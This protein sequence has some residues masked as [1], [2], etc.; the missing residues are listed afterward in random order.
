MSEITNSFQG[1]FPVNCQQKSISF[2][3]LSMCSLLIDG[4]DPTPNNVSQAALYVSQVIMFSYEKQSKIVRTNE[5]S[6]VNRRHLKKRET[7]LSL[8]LG[9]KLMTMRA[10]TIIQKRFLLG[11]CISYDRC[12]DI[13]NNIVVSMLEKIA[14]DAVFTGNSRK[15]LFIIIAKD[16]TDVNS[17]STKVG[18]H[19]HGTSLTIMPFL[20]N[21][22]WFA[23]DFV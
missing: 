7:L 2:P 5:T 20:S 3:L 23:T 6:L 15:N 11:I 10:K 4:E 13:C 1:N 22:Q 16:N 19:Y 17:K 14:N 9:L 21:L 18:Q 12:L 8:Y